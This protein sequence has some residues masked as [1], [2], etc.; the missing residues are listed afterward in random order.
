MVGAVLDDDDGNGDGEANV[1][2]T[3]GISDEG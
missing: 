2:V 3:L 1:G